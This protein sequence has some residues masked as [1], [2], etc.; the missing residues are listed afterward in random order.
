MHRNKSVDV[1]QFSMIPRADIPRSKFD[2][3][4][5]YKTTFDSGYLVPVFVDEVLP[6]DTIN[7]QMT[8]FARLATPLFPVMDNMHLDSF[9]FFVPNRLV[10]ENWQKFMG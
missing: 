1:H 7:L 3:Q 8:A 6:G 9:F 2:R 5:G 4:S 10:W